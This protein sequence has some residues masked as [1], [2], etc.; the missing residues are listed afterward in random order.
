VE[1]ENRRLHLTN[2]Q[3]TATSSSLTQRV[4]SLTSQVDVLRRGVTTGSHDDHVRF[5]M[6]QAQQFRADFESEKRDR[7]AAETRV[8]ELQ[9]QLAAAS[10][11]VLY[12]L[13]SFYPSL[14]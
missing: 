6:E 7:I 11:Q 12:L 10:T 8:I 2:D 4:E 3:L 1:D 14:L 13:F 9:Q 5:L